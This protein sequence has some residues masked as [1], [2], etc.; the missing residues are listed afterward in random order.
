M[1]IGGRKVEFDSEEHI[2]KVDGKI[3]PNV[4]TILGST[5]FKG[6]YSDVPLE[7]LEKARMFGSEVH[8]A[9]EF[10]EPMFLN[11]LQKIKYCEFFDL[12]KK[13]DIEIIEKEQIVYYVVDDKV[14][15]IGKFDLIV[16]Y[17][18]DLMISDIKTTYNLDRQYLSWQLSMYKLAWEQLYGKELKK[19][20]AFWLPKRKASSLHSIKFK[21]KQEILKV[22]EIY[23][24]TIQ[25]Q[26]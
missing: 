17:A 20:L 4:S 2:Y 24:D 7:V 16:K 6:K 23:G 1:I 3:A 13:N 21:T 14:I 26:R 10:E 15:Y 22:V 25:E 5:L 9:I 12:I 18:N 19:G 11:N 8:N